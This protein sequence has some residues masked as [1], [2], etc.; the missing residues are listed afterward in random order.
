MA[1]TY[2]PSLY[3]WA[4]GMPAF[5]RL[6]ATFYA[7]VQTDLLLQPVFAQMDPQRNWSASL[8]VR[9]NHSLVDTGI[10]RSMRHPMYAAFWRCG[11]AQ[12]LL[13]HNWIAGFSYL[14]S[15]VPMYVLRVP[16]EEQ[17]MLDTFGDR[18]RAYMAQTGRIIPKIQDLRSWEVW[19]AKPSKKSPSRPLSAASPR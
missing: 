3:A 13:L 18:Y 7:K 8:V 15:F 2:P 9:A 11:I 10:Y 17:M 16:Q 5:E 6:T 12:A 19:R 4:G 1:D 14:A